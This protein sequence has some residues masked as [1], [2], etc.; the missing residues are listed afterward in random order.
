[1]GKAPGKW[2]LNKVMLGLVGVAAV[3]ACGVSIF[4][5][6]GARTN[7]A[8]SGS[9]SVVVTT[10]PVAASEPVV[11]VTEAAGTTPTTAGSTAGSATPARTTKPTPAKTTTKAVYY[12][13]CDAVHDAGLA[14]LGRN[15]PG[16]R[17]ALDRDG[18]GVA[19]ESGDSDTD[20]KPE[21]GSGGGTDPRYATCAAA[22][23]AGY[24]PYTEGVD[25][26]YD[27][28]QD[29]DNDGVVCE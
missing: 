24:G 11:P 13:N 4:A 6:G 1:M 20:D 3:A 21:T 9:P 19:C 8:G 12:A 14:D 29:R 28:Y 10:D 23:K 27:W 5:S 17:K 25:P 7:T 22:K 16:Y 18:D 2:S 15:D 26:E